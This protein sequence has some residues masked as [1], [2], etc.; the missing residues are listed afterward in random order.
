MAAD[1]AICRAPLS[2]FIVAAA[3]S[4]RLM[5]YELCLFFELRCRIMSLRRR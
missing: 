1:Y 4:L 3:L 5:R 2:L